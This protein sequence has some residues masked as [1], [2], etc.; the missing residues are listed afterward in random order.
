[1][2]DTSDAARDWLAVWMGTSHASADDFYAY[3]AGIDEFDEQTPI[4]LDFGTT[5]IDV[6]WWGSFRTLGLRVLPIEELVREVDTSSLATDAA[7][8]EAAKAMGCITCCV[9]SF[10]PSSRGAPTTGCTSSATSLTLTSPTKRRASVHPRRA[11]S[12]WWLGS[13]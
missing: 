3:T 5:F 8:V 10:I 2:I 13:M 9:A 4:C 7:I 12:V 11:E 6:D 1:M